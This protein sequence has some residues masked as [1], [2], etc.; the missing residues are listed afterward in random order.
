MRWRRRCLEN[1]VEETLPCGPSGN[2]STLPVDEIPVKLT[3]TTVDIH[4]SGAK[5]SLALPEVTSNPE[6][7][8]NENGKVSLEE[9][10]SS[11]GLLAFWEVE[12]RD[13]S[14]ELRPGLVYA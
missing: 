5:P 3:A 14:V 1:A 8:N 13:S 6:G 10:R 11:S 2:L 12:R 4:L 9:I 7:G